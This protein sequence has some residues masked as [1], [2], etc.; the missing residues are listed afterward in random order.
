MQPR[1]L[2]V[3][4]RFQITFK[5]V[6]ELVVAYSANLSRGGLFLQTSRCAPVGT[7]I[8]LVM[9]LPDGGNEVELPCCVV[10]VRDA[11]DKIVWSAIAW[12]SMLKD[13]RVYRTE[14]EAGEA[15]P[16]RDRV[17]RILDSVEGRFEFVQCEV[18]APDE[19]QSSTSSLILEH[20]RRLDEGGF[21]PA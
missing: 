10:Y 4:A 14:L 17:Y 11:S 13:G 6:D 21:S 7:T 15:L 3:T 18:D 1:D 20:A 16:T 9:R 12:A 2:R 19:V 8:T 5:T